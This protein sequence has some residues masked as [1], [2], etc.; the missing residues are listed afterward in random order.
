MYARARVCV[1]HPTDPF[2]F[3]PSPDTVFVSADWPRLDA[4]NYWNKTALS[5]AGVPSVRGGNLTEANMR[6]IVSVTHTHTHTLGA[7]VTEAGRRVIVSDTQARAT[8]THTTMGLYVPGWAW[9][10][11]TAAT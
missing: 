4:A 1:C 3:N 5:E 6:A 9:V 8:Y 7:N 10:S 11:S 2:P